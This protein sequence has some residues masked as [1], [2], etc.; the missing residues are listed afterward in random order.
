MSDIFYLVSL[1]LTGNLT[2]AIYVQEIFLVIYPYMLVAAVPKQRVRKTTAVLPP[3]L[4]DLQHHSRQPPRPLLQELLTH[5]F[6]IAHHQ[7]QYTTIGHIIE[8]EGVDIL[9]FYRRE[10]TV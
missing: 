8:Q 4:I 6:Q 9:L 1:W 5:C 10:C 7:V 2:S 3:G